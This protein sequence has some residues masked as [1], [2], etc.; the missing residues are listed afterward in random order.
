MKKLILAGLLCCTFCFAF[1]TASN[2]I[3]FF[4][5]PASSDDEDGKCH[6]CRKKYQETGDK[7]SGDYYKE[8]CEKQLNVPIDHRE[9]NNKDKGRNGL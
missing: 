4:A 5:Q 7:K 1:A 8:N 6:D 9:Q 3:W 2:A